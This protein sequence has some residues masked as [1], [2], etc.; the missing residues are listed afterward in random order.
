MKGK[1]NKDKKKQAPI[2]KRIPMKD[3]LVSKG[4]KKKHSKEMHSKENAL[5]EVN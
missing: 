3:P 4:R 1:I 2:S 5:K